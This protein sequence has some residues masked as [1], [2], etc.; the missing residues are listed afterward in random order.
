MKLRLVKLPASVLLLLLLAVCGC[1]TTHFIVPAPVIREYD[2]PIPAKCGF[3][4]S[5][6]LRDQWYTKKD[7][8]TRIDVPIGKVVLDF[9]LANLKRAFQLPEHTP[10]DTDPTVVE[11][12]SVLR[13]ESHGGEAGLRL[14][15][16]AIEFMIENGTAFAKL[17][18][19]LFENPRQ[20]IFTKDYYGKGT[21]EQAAGL[22]QKT[23]YAQNNIELSTAAALTMIYQD[24]LDDIRIAVNELQAA[25]A[26]VPEPLPPSE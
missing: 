18:F 8:R 12:F 6:K 15:L 26:T 20:A 25:E 7:G 23:I 13:Y 16:N 3:L 9:A 17:N 4:M 14:K 22:L 2:Q 1:S 11:D 5:P 24:L 10:S 19:T 21:P